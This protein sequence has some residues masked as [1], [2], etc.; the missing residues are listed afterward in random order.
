MDF[1]LEVHIE[2]SQHLY[3]MAYE[4]FQMHR[5][6]HDREEAMQ[7]LHRMNTAI[8]A[9][10]PA[11]QARRHAEFERDLTERFAYFDSQAAHQVVGRRF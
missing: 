1:E 4:R 2:D 6:P 3:L 11:E 7:H 10:S 5:N 8:L 9:R